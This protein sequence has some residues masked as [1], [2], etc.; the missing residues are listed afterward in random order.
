M[1]EKIKEL[2]INTPIDGYQL[3]SVVGNGEKGVVFHATAHTPIEDE[4]A[5]KIIPATLASTGWENE[6]NKVT[7]LGS[8][9][10]VP[11][12]HRHGEIEKDG[13]KYLWI[14]WDY[15][16]GDSLKK[17]INEKKL[18]I[19]I[20]HDVVNRIL[21]VLHACKAVGIQ[22]GD[23]HSGNIMIGE[24]NPL[25]IDSGD[26]AI[27]V[28]DFGFKTATIVKDSGQ[29][30]DDYIGL[31]KIISESVELIDFHTLP[32]AEKIKYLTLKNYFVRYLL[33][34]NN[35]EDS[36]SRDPRSLLEKLST[37]PAEFAESNKVDTKRISDYLAAELIGERYDEWKSLFVEE[38]AAVDRLTDSNTVLF[39]GLRGCGKTM[40]FKRLSAR[41]QLELGP[42]AGLGKLN[43]QGF[44]VNA[45]NLT[46]AFPWLPNECKHGAKNQIIH[47][48][49]ILFIAEVVRWLI[50]LYRR[51]SASVLVA[52]VVSIFEDLFPGK[53]LFTGGESSHLSH[54]LAFLRKEERGSKLNGRYDEGRCYECCGYNFLDEFF[55]DLSKAL[56]PSTNRHFFMLLDD[57]SMPMVSAVMQ[58]ILNPV[59]FRRSANVVYKVS[60]ENI[61]TFLSIGMNGKQLEEDHD[62]NLVD[63][64]GEVIL[65]DAKENL[66]FLDKVFKPRID[67]HEALSGRS[68]TLEKVM[69]K[70][71]DNFNDMARRLIDEKNSDCF[72]GVDVFCSI[73]SG[74][75]REMISVFAN[76]VERSSKTNLQSNGSPL[77]PV[78][79]QNTALK[80]EGGRFVQ[81][82]RSAIYPFIGKYETPF[83]S[84]FGEHLHRFCLSLQ[85]ISRH[86]LTKKTVKNQNHTNP[87]QARR[88][89][90]YNPTELPEHINSIY[91]GLI[92]YGI[93]IR[94]NRG[95]SV[96]DKVSPRHYFRGIVIPFFCIS[97]SK[98]D[99]I[100]VTWDQFCEWLNNPDDFTKKWAL[101]DPGKLDPKQSELKL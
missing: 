41:F 62:Y 36:C 17:F 63:V 26:R 82:L 61:D 69:G 24:P 21:R 50:A 39:T 46:E 88:I 15:I 96:R 7:K 98:H 79:V 72:S 85:E 52:K 100:S 89:E 64:S 3:T 19:Q 49:H 76:M 43:F 66:A 90:I 1:N 91:K 44:Y 84:S 27:W 95:K 83:F 8:T 2:F 86:E 75:L 78:D 30:L 23:L 42:P 34:S 71:Q 18:T 47:F 87:K 97:P 5:I 45:R 80:E 9:Q 67:R 101:D 10:G 53:I 37:L 35:I 22:H 25:E 28:I 94:D 74:N 11:R 12:F 14:R 99:S 59:I 92:R 29:I 13:I 6:I 54:I 58:E 93:L 81:S 40:V 32:G 38:F 33:E 56:V 31:N 48:M 4:S 65:R 60:T 57:Y 70:T 55:S 20:I 51:D 68:L 73:W 77:I 16:R